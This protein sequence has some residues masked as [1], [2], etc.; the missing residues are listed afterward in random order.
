MKVTLEDYTRNPEIRIGYS[1]AECYDSRRDDAA[2]IKRAAHC[3]DSGHLTTLRFAYATVR[4]EGISRVCSH[5]LVRMAHSGILMRSQRYVAETEVNYID[6]PKWEALDVSYKAEWYHIQRRAEAL[7][8]KLVELGHMKKE[9]A[10]YILPQ[11]CA[12]SLVM[13]L[14]FQAWLDFLRNRDS[15]HAQWEIREVAQ[16]IRKRLHGI[17]PNIFKETAE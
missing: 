4:V 12:T 9:D 16:E 5:Q 6:P 14:N 7:Y 17:A 2:C 1:A 11:G 10:R 3:V 8:L 13:C 15:K